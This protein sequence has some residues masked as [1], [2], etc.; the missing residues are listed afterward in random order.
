MIEALLSTGRGGGGG[1]GLGYGPL[2]YLLIH[3]VQQLI[4]YS[5]RWWGAGG[6]VGFFCCC[7]FNQQRNTY[8]NAF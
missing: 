1:G 8:L 6:I 5:C 2:H 4:A 7:C 3:L